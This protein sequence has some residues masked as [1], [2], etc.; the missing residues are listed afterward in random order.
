MKNKAEITFATDSGRSGFTLIESMVVMVLITV[1]FLLIA[2]ILWGAIKI[3]RADAAAFD[4]LVAQSALADQF[5]QDVAEAVEAP[6]SLNDLTAGPACLI[7]KMAE[8]GSVTYRW[9][10]GSLR[11]KE[12]VG[13]EVS[14]RS[15]PVGRE[16][17]S[18]EFA[19]SSTEGRLIILR[20]IEWR[21]AG[22]SRGEHRIEFSAA[23]GG[24]LQ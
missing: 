1:F 7:L 23:L 12:L 9:D 16:D 5:R 19:R 2:A 13:T 11:R 10:N 24:D 20:L 3:E 17:V 15:V 14:H 6:Q 21:G 22:G 4:R 8:G 18:V